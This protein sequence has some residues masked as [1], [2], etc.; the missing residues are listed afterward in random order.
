MRTFIARVEIRAPARSSH[1]RATT[2]RRSSTARP[3]WCCAQALRRAA[4]NEPQFSSKRRRCCP[5]GST[6]A[7]E[8]ALSSPSR[9]CAGASRTPRSPTWP[10]RSCL[11]QQAAATLPLEW[12]FG[13]PPRNDRGREATALRRSLL[14]VRPVLARDATAVVVARP[15]RRERPGRRRARRRRRRL[16]AELGTAGRIGQPVQPACS[17]STSGRRRATATVT[18]SSA[19]LAA[20]R[21]RQ[22]LRPGR[23]RGG[24]DRRRGERPPGSWRAGASRAPAGEVLIGLDRLGHLRRLVGTQTFSE[25]EAASDGGST[26]RAGPAGS[27]D[28]APDAD[29]RADAATDETDDDA[30][31]DADA[32][33]DDPGHSANRADPPVASPPPDWALSSA[34]ATDHVRLLMEIVM[35]EL[36]RPDHPRLLEVEPGRWWL[37]ADRDLAQARPP[38]SDRLEWAVF[39]LLSTS[40]GIDEGS[41]SSAS[42]ACSAATTRLIRS[43]SGHVLESYRDPASSQ[44]ALRPQDALTAR[45]VEHGELVGTARRVRPSPGSARSR[46]RARSAGASYRGAT[47]G[48]LLSED[49]QRA[50]VPLIAAGDAAHAR[51]D[52]LHLVPARQGHV[53]VRGRVDGDDHRRRCC[54]AVRASPADETIV[55]FLVIPPERVEL[56]RLQA[57]AVAAA[58]SSARRP[59]LAYPQVRSPAPAARPRRGG[60]RSDS[61]RCSVWTRRSNAKPSS[62]RSSAD[63]RPRR[64]ARGGNSRDRS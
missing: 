55:R 37:R 4:G 63:C 11:A 41:S 18:P 44:V 58:A 42:R 29:A 52:R 47:V 56:V 14:A 5:A 26:E 7:A 51:V 21:S 33:A 49:E 15:R 16:S 23:R 54:D 17:S 59:E 6:R 2:W 1:G 30:E 35:G 10:R 39:G 45:H 62:F 22:A 20:G 40:Q 60:P 34:S 27:L 25:T 36:R 32:D 8:C 28:L 3:M 53:H 57:G 13:P 12:V 46:L 50:Y 61:H 19:R 38:L 24:S 31:D 48:D 64:A 43:W 9:R